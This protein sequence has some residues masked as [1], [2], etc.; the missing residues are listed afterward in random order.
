MLLQGLKAG[1]L[2]IVDFLAVP[3]SEVPTEKSSIQHKETRDMEDFIENEEEHQID[4]NF[5]HI[6]TR[7]IQENEQDALIHPGITKVPM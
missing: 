2:G 4:W 6:Y 1:F 5:L 7:K 3:K